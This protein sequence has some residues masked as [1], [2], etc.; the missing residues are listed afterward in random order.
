MTES[1]SPVFVVDGLRTAIGRYGGGLAS[2]RPD[3]LAAAVVSGL[4]AKRDGLRESVDQ[5]V[6]GATNQAGEDNRTMARMALLLA[7][8]PDEAPGFTATRL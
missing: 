8:L 7:G 2:I 5:V 4:V 6:F 3:D 1:L